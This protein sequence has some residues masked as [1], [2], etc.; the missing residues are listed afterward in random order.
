MLTI[1]WWQS[2][3]AAHRKG[4]LNFPPHFQSILTETRS[5]FMFLIPGRLPLKVVFVEGRLRWRS[6]SSKV[7]LHRRS[8]CIEGRLASKVVLHGRLSCMEGFLPLKVVFRR[9][10][11]SIKV[12]LPSKVVFCQRSSSIKGHLPS[13]VVFRQRLSSVKMR[14]PAKIVFR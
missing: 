13:K 7:I 11:S 8:S 12:R 3:N 4:L 5:I 6:F 2:C 14:L 9:R 1:R 10:S